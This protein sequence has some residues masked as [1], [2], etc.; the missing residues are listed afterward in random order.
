[1]PLVESMHFGLPVLAY[2]ATA[3]PETLGQAG[4]LFNRF[5]YAEIAE[6]AHLMVTD[7]VLRQQIVRRQHQRLSDLSPE[8][9][10][11]KLHQILERMGVLE[12]ADG[13]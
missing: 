4:V 8:R 3:V 12:W 5:C 11:G 1:M 6:M 7:P 10:E 2:N 13:H 9:V